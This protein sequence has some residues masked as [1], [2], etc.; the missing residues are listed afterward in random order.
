MPRPS[1]GEEEVETP[2]EHSVASGL[3]LKTRAPR[4]TTLSP[5]DLAQ[6]PTTHLIGMI[7]ALTN[8]LEKRLQQ[9]ERSVEVTREE[10]FLVQASR[11]QEE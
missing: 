11:Q 1:A 10:V 7:R 3:P 6:W 4:D 8:Q 5:V 2:S 9:A